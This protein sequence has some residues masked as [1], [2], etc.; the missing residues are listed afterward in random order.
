MNWATTVWKTITKKYTL[1]YTYPSK[2]FFISS[3]IYFM[4]V[5]S[6]FLFISMIGRSNKEFTK[7]CETQKHGTVFYEYD[8]FM[9]V[10]VRGE[11]IN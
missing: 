7:E 1:T 9:L 5:C 3:I 10:C 6:P 4:I 8:S 11:K 2:G